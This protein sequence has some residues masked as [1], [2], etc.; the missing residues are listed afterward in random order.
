MT[1]DPTVSFATLM[2]AIEPKEYKHED[3]SKI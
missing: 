1:C 3:L 2:Q